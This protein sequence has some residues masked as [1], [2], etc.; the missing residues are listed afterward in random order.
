MILLLSIVVWGLVFVCSAPATLRLFGGKGEEYDAV[1]FSYILFS[2]IVLGFNFRWAFA[3]D[4]M[5]AVEVFRLLGAAV[6]VF[7]L[8]IIRF[9]RRGN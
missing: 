5:V 4:S 1:K 8:I 7:L 9:Y 3:P 6:A 2:I